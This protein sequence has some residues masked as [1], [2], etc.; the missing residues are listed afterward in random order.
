M[1]ELCN[2]DIF[3]SL[4]NSISTDCNCISLTLLSF[5]FNLKWMNRERGEEEGYKEG[6]KRGWRGRVAK[7]EEGRRRKGDRRE[8]GEKKE[9][10]RGWGDSRKRS[11]NQRH[12]MEFSEKICLSSEDWFALGTQ[13]WGQCGR[14]G[15]ATIWNTS[16]LYRHQFLSRHF[17]FRSSTL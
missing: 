4:F 2:T 5:F 11:C 14:V 3:L 6:S 9:E 15:K 7:W 8:E 1:L 16:I 10:R 12:V 17:H 13:G